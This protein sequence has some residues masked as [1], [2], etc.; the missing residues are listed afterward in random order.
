[1]NI[2]EEIEYMREKIIAIT[3][4]EI[5]R[6]FDE[7]KMRLSD[8]ELLAVISDEEAEPMPIC[9]NDPHY[10]IGTKPA[11]L[12]VGSKEYTVKSWINVVRIVLTQINEAHHYKLSEWAGKYSG[13]SRIILGNT[14]EGMDKPIKIDDDIYLKVTVAQKQL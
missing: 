5:D 12:F 11:K 3:N 10:F 8:D 6:Y 14:G 13:R 1:M 7:L 2:I 9:F 4:R